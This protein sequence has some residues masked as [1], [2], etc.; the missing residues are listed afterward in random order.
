M[1]AE[2]MRNRRRLT[3]PCLFMTLGGISYRQRRRDWKA[4]LPGTLGNIYC[5]AVSVPLKELNTPRILR[6][7]TQVAQEAAHFPTHFPLDSIKKPRAVI[8]TR[9]RVFPHR[10][11]I[12][13]TNIPAI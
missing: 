5:T 8:A 6:L 12:T 7:K 1:A 10:I 4:A 3:N 2:S 9:Y 13:T 11:L